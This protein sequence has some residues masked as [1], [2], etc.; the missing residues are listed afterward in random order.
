MAGYRTHVFFGGL[1]GVAAGVAAFLT[2]WCTPVQSAVLGVFGMIG[3]ALPDIDGKTSRPRRLLLGI[4]GVGVPVLLA[5]RLLPYDLTNEEFFCWITGSYLVISFGLDFLLSRFSRHRGAFHSIPAAILA[6]EGAFLMFAGSTLQ[7]RFAFA[8]A[9]AGGYL[10]HLLLDELWSVN[11]IGIAEKKSAGSAFTWKTDS[12]FG[13][14]LLY[15][16]VALFGV[17]CAF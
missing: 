6:G 17:L 4:L 12:F 9:V 16:A 3:A 2:G 8:L 7:A 10:S 5:G 15:L 11:F 1:W 13:T 14:L